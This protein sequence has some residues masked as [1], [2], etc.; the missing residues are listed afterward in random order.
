MKNSK[1]SVSRAAALF[2]VS[3]ALFY[4]MAIFNFFNGN[5]A[6]TGF[7]WLG[8]GSAFLCIASSLK[9]KSKKDKDDKNE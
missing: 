6:D 7:I 2:Y 3:S 1:N 5:D 9:V 8:L 4:L